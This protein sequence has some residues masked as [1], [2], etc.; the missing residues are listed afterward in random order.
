VDAQHTTTIRFLGVA[1]A[2]ALALGIATG[3]GSSSGS[4]EAS[5]PASSA[6]A[7]TTA[8]TTAPAPSV[9][10]VTPKNGWTGTQPLHVKVALKN[11]RLSA[12]DVGKAAVP[13]EGHL[14]FTMDNGKYDFPKFSGANGKLAV[15]LGVQGKYSPSVTPG[16]TYRNLPAGQHTIVVHLANNDHTNVGPLARVTFTLG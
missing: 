16:I 9:A 12:A 5:T 4:S 8:A 13:G 11:F 2:G 15:T 10:F 3:C 14:H 6:N 1:A 7:A